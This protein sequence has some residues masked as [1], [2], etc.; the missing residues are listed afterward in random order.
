MAGVNPRIRTINVLTKE[1]KTPHY[2]EREILNAMVETR[3]ILHES[4]SHV[5]VDDQYEQKMLT[6]MVGEYEYVFRRVLQ[7]CHGTK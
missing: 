2:S 3:K 4:I 7:Q 5:Y 1:G 6:A